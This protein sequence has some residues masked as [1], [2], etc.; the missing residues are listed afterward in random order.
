MRQN[1]A[2]SLEIGVDG[3][4]TKA[5]CAPEQGFAGPTPARTQKELH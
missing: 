3:Y 4:I 1:L 2:K 5:E